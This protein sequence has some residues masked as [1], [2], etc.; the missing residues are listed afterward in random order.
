MNTHA[1]RKASK[2]IRQALRSGLRPSSSRSR[3]CALASAC[4]MRAVRSAS[5]EGAALIST[6]GVLARSLLIGL[7]GLPLMA[8]AVQSEGV[9]T[10]DKTLMPDQAAANTLT[11]PQGELSVRLGIGNARGLYAVG[12]M[13]ELSVETNT[14]AWVTVL[15]IGV[16]GTTTVLYPYLDGTDN[17]VL[18]GTPKW[19][20]GKDS[21]VVIRF[22]APAGTDLVRAFAS[23][24]KIPLLDPAMIARVTPRI[25][26][27][28]SK[29]R[30][31]VPEMQQT[32]DGNTDGVDWAEDT[33]T[34]TS[35]D[36]PVPVAVDVGQ[37]V[38]VN[39]P[40]GLSIRTGKLV[41]ETGEPVKI[42]VT[43]ARACNLTVYNIG[44]SG[45]VR[46]IFPNTGRPE[47][48]V[49][50]GETVRIPDENTFLASVGP[51]GAESIVA[52]CTSDAAATLGVDAAFAEQLFPTV[53]D[54]TA[55]NAR[56][57]SVISTP[58][59]VLLG[60]GETAR[61]VATILVR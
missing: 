35:V 15:N 45:A 54:W 38:S 5:E 2:Q 53:G 32:I 52:L 57:L 41:Y 7:L 37:T 55:L 14:D 8:T 30:N 13:L 60:H 17:L 31:L 47:H 16:D 23:T 58:D 26:Q 3:A 36:G 34:V 1:R 10:F 11:V 43:P 33:L 40:F 19:I 49:A 12:D 51:A 25:G 6:G 4:V 50:A 59:D 21:G 22:H 56:D 61:A 20:S 44:T 28:K 29:V 9:A 48:S 24:R 46:Q 18:G 39:A 42:E 27:A